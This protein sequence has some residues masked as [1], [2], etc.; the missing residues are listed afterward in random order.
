MPKIDRELG[1]EV[2]ATGTQGVGGAIRESVDD[3]VVEEV[4]VD[5][6]RATFGKTPGSRT[7][8]V[9][10]AE[11]DYLLCVLAKRNWDTFIAIKNIARQLGIRQEQIAIAGI[12]DAKAVTAPKYV[13]VLVIVSPA[14]FHV[15]PSNPKKRISIQKTVT[16]PRLWSFFRRV[17]VSFGTRPLSKD[18]SFPRKACPELAEGRES[19]LSTAHFRKFAEW[20]P[21]P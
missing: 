4:L 5:G 7:F 18:Q 12:K 10:S 16:P 17:L 3:F 8:R 14:K 20:I 1:I 19:S 6:S 13:I 11:Q 9:T 2:Y 21:P 15:G